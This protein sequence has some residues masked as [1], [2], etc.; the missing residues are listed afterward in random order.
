MVIPDVEA[1]IGK[2][3]FELLTEMVNVLN[4]KHRR[5][6]LRA[7]F[8]DMKNLFK[9]LGIAIPPNLRNLEVVMGW[10]A[11][12]VDMLASRVRMS[13]FVLP[14]GDLDGFGI[15]DMVSGTGDFAGLVDEATTSALIHATAF[16]LTTPGD[17]AAGEPEVVFSVHDAFTATGKWS[18]RRRGLE[19]GLVV[20]STDQL[21]NP[22]RYLLLT[23]VSAADMRLDGHRWQVRVTQHDLGRVP[24]EPITYKRRTL[25]PF[26]SSRISR[27]VMSLTESAMR[28]VARAEVGA[29]FF[30]APQR[31]LL[32]ADEKSFE[33][34]N[35]ERKT[36]WNLVTG[37]MLMFPDAADADGNS[38]QIGQFPQVS[39]QPHT[40][41][42]RMWASMF[43]AETGLPVGSLGI[44]Q[45]NPSSAEAIFAAKEDLVIEA[46]KVTAAFGPAWCRSL[47]TGVQ[48]RDGLSSAPR[49]LAGLAARWYDASTPSR[50]QA[51]DAVMK[52]IS[53]GVLPA[54]SDVAMERLGYSSSDIERVKAHRLVAGPQGLAGLIGAVTR[55]NG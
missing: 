33:G 19:A 2:P 26:G 9:D 52:E 29:E 50:A 54:D 18:A 14:G 34:P 42:M 30:S 47:V 36:L 27:A 55:Q 44:V 24:L 21:G 20:L 4:A 31:Y 8:Y 5:N 45:D 25:R 35:G 40:E 32:G 12:T 51:A 48:L 15:P 46:E 53:A 3:A 38:L 11:K 28:T 13:G 49:E 7:D 1:K 43:A 23:P 41:Q 16:I 37:R 17:P 39:M 22:T 6:Q 10:P